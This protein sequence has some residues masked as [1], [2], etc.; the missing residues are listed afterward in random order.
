MVAGYTACVLLLAVLY[1][2]VPG[3]RAA[4]W[5]LLG[6]T[7][8]AGCWPGR[9]S[10]GRPPGAL[11]LLAAGSLTSLAGQV[12]A[13]ASAGPGGRPPPF[14]SPADVCDLAA[15]PLY[16]AGLVL[17]I[18]AR[19]AGRD[20]RG[21]LDTLTVTAGG[22]VLAWLY[23]V[24]P[25]ARAAGL[26]GLGRTAA[27]GYPLGD[28]LMLALL[29]G[30]LARLL[31]EGGGRIRSVQLLALGGIALLA[32]DVGYSRLLEQDGSGRRLLAVS[33]GWAVCY[34]A[35]GAAALHPSM[36]R[37]TQPGLRQPPQRSPVRLALLLLAALIA[38]AVLLAGA[39]DRHLPDAA[40]IAICSAVL[41]LLVISRLADTTRSLRVALDRT[42]VLR[43]AGES[44]AAA[45]TEEQAASVVRAAVSSLIAPPRPQA[46]QLAVRDSGTLRRSVPRH[47]SRPGRPTCPRR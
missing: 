34:A 10:T 2:L 20:R 26:S 37:L 27:I 8:V 28:L 22:A 24:L 16:V 42:Q 45:A 14:P 29:A 46:V 40:V 43:A 41:Y 11:A 32:A 12:L 21:L 36:T 13:L 38:P 1:Y 35:W 31:A 7:G 39:L 23:L 6:L 4:A 18:R 30:L 47:G 15:Y 17:F 3:L 25:G 9:A 5:S 33:A 44:L 19:T